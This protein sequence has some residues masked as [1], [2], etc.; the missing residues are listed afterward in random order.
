M[1]DRRNIIY[2]P[3]SC[4]NLSSVSLFHFPRPRHGSPPTYSNRRAEQ[5]GGKALGQ[6]TLF[7][8]IGRDSIA[9]LWLGGRDL[10]LW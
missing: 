1:N 2:V 3:V 8:A 9:G 4:L 6:S 5:D 7:P 10:L